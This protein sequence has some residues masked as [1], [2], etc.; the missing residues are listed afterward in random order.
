[1]AQTC[2]RGADLMYEYC[3]QHD[4]PVERCGKLVV[5]CNEKEHEQVE[6]LYHQGTANGVKGLKIISCDEVNF[7]QI[8]IQSTEPLIF[9]FYR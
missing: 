4:L 5:A 2:V 1:M 8:K 6:K 9:F 3:E 7:L